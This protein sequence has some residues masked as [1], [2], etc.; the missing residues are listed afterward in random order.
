M[1]W[2]AAIRWDARPR[3]I[4]GCF[5]HDDDERPIPVMSLQPSVVSD[6]WRALCRV[7]SDL[8][9]HPAILDAI[10]LAGDGT[11]VVRYAAILWGDIAA[12]EKARTHGARQLLDAYAHLG[13]HV[14]ADQHWLFT[15]PQIHV[16]LGLFIRIAFLP[17]ECEAGPVDLA[18]FARVL[19]EASGLRGESEVRQGIRLVAW[20]AAEEGIGFLQL[21][22]YW[23]AYES[24]EFAN[25][26]RSTPLTRWGLERC[27]RELAIFELA[28]VWPFENPYRQIRPYRDWDDVRPV[29]DALE[30]A[31]DFS[32]A[33]IQYDQVDA[34]ASERA[35]VYTR[36]A[37]C[38]LELHQTQQ[39]IARAKAALLADPMRADAHETLVRAL[40]EHRAYAEALSAANTF[41]SRAPHLGVAHYLRGK[42]LLALGRPEDAREV[43]DLALVLKPT[44]IEGLL[45][46]R[47]ADRMLRKLGKTVGAQRV[48]VEIP[49]SLEHLRE[50]LA[51]GRSKNIIEALSAPS[52]AD[53]GEAQLMLARFL[54]FAERLDDA[55]AI[56]DR[57]I[58][59]PHR[60]AALIGKAGAFLDQGRIES[61]LALFDIAVAERPTDLDACEGRARTLDT[62]GRI[63]EAAAE[64][65]RFIALGAQRAEIRVRAA[66]L[67]LDAH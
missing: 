54:G 2:L 6:P 18:A 23:L 10:G 32:Q 38:H 26:M 15:N 49:A 55:I 44:L 7:W 31:R 5:V 52:L 46:R 8:P 59:S 19:A 63:G 20:H 4:E 30:A 29:V 51:S 22:R 34:K 53:D 58:D 11:L 14:P 57:W 37:R 35:D 41:C 40:I 17:P 50:I 47:E 60:L 13:E 45:L 24:F 9:P 64:F 66:Q 62:L 65:R 28:F 48:S 56:Y 33:V 1:D 25:R 16:D 12:G 67:W 61:A 21:G 27:R 36:H 3:E 42:A 39:A 43:F